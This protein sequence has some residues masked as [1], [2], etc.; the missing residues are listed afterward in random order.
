MRPHNSITLVLLKTLIFG[1]CD[2]DNSMIPLTCEFTKYFI[3]LVELFLVTH[4]G[5]NFLVFYGTRRFIR[6]WQ[7]PAITTH[8]EPNERSSQLYILFKF[9]ISLSSFH[10]CLGSLIGL[11]SSGCR[12]Q[13]TIWMHFTRPPCRG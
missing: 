12:I 11:L 5:K 7:Q 3:P 4:L 10:L 2:S 6:Y 8:P 9:L 1:F 13:I